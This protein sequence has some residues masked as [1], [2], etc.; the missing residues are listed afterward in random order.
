[1]VRRVVG[2]PAADVSGVEVNFRV[3]VAVLIALRV[4][5]PTPCWRRSIDVM[6]RSGDYV[7]TS[8]R[9]SSIPSVTELSCSLLVLSSHR[10]RAGRLYQSPGA[11]QGRDGNLGRDG[12]FGYFGT[13]G[14]G[15]AINTKELIR[16]SSISVQWLVQSIGLG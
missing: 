15:D 14:I 10:E 1:M 9:T 13:V 3:T 16:E 2:V 4:N 5:H 6:R 7:P 12:H 8:F 11:L